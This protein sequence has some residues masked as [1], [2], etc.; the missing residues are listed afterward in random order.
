MVIETAILQK[1]GENSAEYNE[2]HA[3]LMGEGV[4]KT[5]NT[6]AKTWGAD[7]PQMEALQA[8][9]YWYY[10]GGSKND[11]EKL[12]INELP[13]VIPIL[14]KLDE[15]GIDRVTFSA[16][17]FNEEYN[18]TSDDKDWVTFFKGGEP[19]ILDKLRVMDYEVTGFPIWGNWYM[20]INYHS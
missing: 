1:F 7:S 13:S 12:Q 9:V 8:A 14:A 4:A 20:A 15:M 2:F 10:L 16:H 11:A 5:V 18:L 19:Y 6:V 3:L 17:S